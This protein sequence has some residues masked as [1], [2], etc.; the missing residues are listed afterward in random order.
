MPKIDAFVTWLH[1]ASKAFPVPDGANAIT[2]P[3]RPPAAQPAAATPVAR[4]PAP[5]TPI[6]KTRA[7]RKA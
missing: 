4:K 1:A 7:R 5:V 3:A 2:L 6:S